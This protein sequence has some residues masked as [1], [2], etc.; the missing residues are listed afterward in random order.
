[1]ILRLFSLLVGVYAIGF[2][3]F[4]VS[5]GRP[6]P[7]DEV[8]DAAV[9]LTG[10]SGRIE[11]G[12]ERLE[13]QRVDKL[14]IAGADPLVTQADLVEVTGGREGLFDCCI[15]IGSESVDTRTNAEEAKAWIEANDID[16]I[17]LVTSDWHMRRAAFEFRAALGEEVVII[18]DAVPTEPSLLILFS[19]YNKYVLRR[20]GIWAGL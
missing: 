4:A 12:I 16:E 1:M 18:E 17:A 13:Q 15:T 3:L 8:A 6:A 14:L 5:L 19:E 7:E 11:Q 9:V 20:I 2:I 10:G